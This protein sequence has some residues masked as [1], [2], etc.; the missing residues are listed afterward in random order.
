VQICN[1]DL[2][3]IFFSSKSIGSSPIWAS[4]RLVGEDLRVPLIAKVA[5]LNFSFYLWP[6]KAGYA[7]H[8]DHTSFLEWSQ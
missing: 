3:Q 4:S 8:Q 6:Y 5:C 1:K 2:K 7:R